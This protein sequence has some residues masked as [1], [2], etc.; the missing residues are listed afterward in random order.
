MTDF[1]GAQLSRLASR[2]TSPQSFVGVLGNLRRDAV[3]LLGGNPASEALPAEALNA[4]VH[5]LLAD[6]ARA[7]A[8]LR[9]SGPRGLDEFVAWLAAREGIDPARIV[10]TNGGLHALSLV[11]QALL[12]AGDSV[13]TDDPI[14]PIAL[15]VLQLTGAH[16][17]PVPVGRDGLDV[18][19]LERLLA[20]GVRPRAVYTVADFQNP[21]GAVLGARAR[22]RLVEL[23]E[24]FGFVV[25]SD[26]PYRT[27]RFAGEDVPDF[28]TD[29]DRVVRINTFAKS[30]GPGLRLGWLALPS[31]L[32]Q[33]VLN[34][35]ART[36]QHPSTFTQAAILGVVR[37]AGAFDRILADLSA[38]H[39][40]RATTLAT[41]LR[42]H[43]A[44]HIEAE[45]PDGGFFIWARLL[46]P[47][48]SLEPLHHAALAHGTNFSRGTSFAVPGGH[49]HDRHLRLGFSD[50]PDTDLEE[51][52]T[53]LAAAVSTAG[54]G[55]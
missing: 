16:A 52:V 17:V 8:A 19:A 14:F 29:S 28:P 30:L 11:T 55:A 54:G 22:T 15:R 26:N 36:D 41:S 45:R 3:E 23:A 40:S 25:L 20:E 31:W 4:S 32:V 6:P 1:D 35:R 50:I 13:V 47:A 2:L 21:T 39:H 46:D 18:E 27:S 34:I 24:R 12:D 53:R 49:D 10:V 42:T 33:P 48:L 44:G 9:Y 38:L 5:E 7:T 43:L 51:A 37:P